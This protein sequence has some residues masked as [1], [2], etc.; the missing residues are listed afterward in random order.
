MSS[1]D[2]DTE[3]PAK[4]EF[5]RFFERYHGDVYRYA[6]RRLDADRAD[7]VAAETFGVAWRRYDRLPKDQPLPW[8][9]G[10]ARNVIRARR[11]G[12][13]RRGEVLSAEADAGVPA[14]SDTVRQV[15]ERD[16]AL[17]ALER[18]SATDRELVMLLAWEGLELTEAAR[19]L[20]CTTATAR[21]RLHRARRRIERFLDSSPPADRSASPAR[22]ATPGAPHVRVPVEEK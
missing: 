6:V 2:P 10:V 3:E 11:R 12:E 14:A 1:E 5:T 9:Y 16:T 19:V 13:R 22:P 17:R 20:G 15:E 7:D 18:L 21:V 8:L 4:S